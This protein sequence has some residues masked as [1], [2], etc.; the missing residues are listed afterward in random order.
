[1]VYKGKSNWNRWFGPTFILGN[2]HLCARMLRMSRWGPEPVL[3]GHFSE[4][5]VFRIALPILLLWSAKIAPAMPQPQARRGNTISAGRQHIPSI[6]KCTVDGHGELCVLDSALLRSAILSSSNLPVLTKTLGGT[7][8]LNTLPCRKA[9]WTLW[10]TSRMPLEQLNSVKQEEQHPHHFFLSLDSLLFYHRSI[11]DSSPFGPRFQSGFRNH[12]AP[13]AVW[14]SSV[15]GCSSSIENFRVSKTPLT[16]CRTWPSAFNI[17]IRRWGPLL[18]APMEV[19]CSPSGVGR[20]RKRLL[21]VCKSWG[22]APEQQISNMNSSW[23]PRRPVYPA[24]R[25]DTHG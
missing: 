2:L 11:S 6:P 3:K 10:W 5:L 14:N 21:S 16:W 8:F 17:R 20:I 12:G 19:S 15:D 1:M 18:L 23:R 25:E 7:R 13:W 4:L 22:L 9:R 24:P